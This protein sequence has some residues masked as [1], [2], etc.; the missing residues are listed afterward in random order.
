MVIFVG[1]AILIAGSADT[2][3]TSTGGFV[4]IGPVPIV[5]GSGPNGTMLGLLAVAM[6]A[7]LVVL[8]FLFAK[9]V[10]SDSP[11]RER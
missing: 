6:G 10:R 8:L 5:F 9:R 4:I 11:S 1:M 3:S 2:G 7:V